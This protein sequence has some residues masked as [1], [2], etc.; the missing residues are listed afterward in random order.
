MCNE[1]L[2]TELEYFSEEYAKEREMEPRPAR[3]REIT[4]VL[5]YGVLEGP[6]T[7]RKG[8]RV[9]R[10]SKRDGGREKGIIKVEGLWIKK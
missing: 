9:R 10:F 4:L 5:C 3:V 8:G 7:E 1:D 2:R 6:E